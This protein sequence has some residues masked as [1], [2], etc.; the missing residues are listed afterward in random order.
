MTLGINST[1]SENERKPTLELKQINQ[2]AISFIFI[3]TYGTQ[4]L[5]N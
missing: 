4:A 1:Y 2:S 5:L 3:P